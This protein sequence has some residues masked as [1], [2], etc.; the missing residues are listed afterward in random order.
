M[1]A[2][3]TPARA[4]DALAARH[5]RVHRVGLAARE[6]AAHVEERAGPVRSSAAMRAREPRRGRRGLPLAAVATRAAISATGRSSGEEADHVARSPRTLGTRKKTSSCAGALASAS[7]A[8][9]PR[10]RHVGAQRRGG[11]GVAAPAGE[12]GPATPASRAP[13]RALGSGPGRAPRAPTSASERARRASAAVRRTRS[14]VTSTGPEDARRR[15]R[16]PALTGRAPRHGGAR[17]LP[18]SAVPSIS[19]PSG[20]VR[21]GRP[22]RPRRTRLRRP[23]HARAPAGRRRRGCRRR[24]GCAAWPRRR[25]PGGAPRTPS[26]RSPTARAG[27]VDGSPD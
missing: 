23:A 27:R 11:D 4:P 5:A 21:V 22:M 3:G 2:S 26:P 18:M 1:T 8:R 7:R 25:P 17:A 9:E 10:R 12:R 19:V 20:P 24:A 15:A 14:S 6:V 13:R 16:R